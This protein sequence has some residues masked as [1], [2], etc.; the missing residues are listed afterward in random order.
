[1]LLTYKALSLIFFNIYSHAVAI[2]A[3]AI[4]IKQIVK[5]R[6]Q[7]RF[8]DLVIFQLFLGLLRAYSGYLLS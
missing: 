5:A 4:L 6:I 8:P 7:F 1:M 2:L 3:V